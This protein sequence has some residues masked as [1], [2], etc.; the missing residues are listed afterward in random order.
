LTAQDWPRILPAAQEFAMQLGVE[1]RVQTLPG[2]MR[3]IDFG[4]PYD[5][6]FLG[7]ILHNYA[8]AM[9]RE[10]LRK[11]FG[12]LVPGG[13]VIIV[14]F[15]AEPEEPAS[16]FAWLFSTMMYGTQGTRSFAAA[17]IQ[18]MLIDCGASHTEVS[19]RDLL[20]AGFVIGYCA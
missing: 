19:S 11:C 13:R 2:D 16:T 7:H 1:S 17:E 12:A 9:D 15:L 6:V 20:P 10:I 18:Q 8:D 14:E 3:T 5:V 4:G